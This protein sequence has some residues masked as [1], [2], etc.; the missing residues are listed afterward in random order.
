MR[1]LVTGAAGYIGST[2]VP[3]LLKEGH[4]IVALD[5]L[6]WGR[7]GLIQNIGDPNF[8]F[9]EG[10]VRDPLLVSSL[11]EGSDV[12]VHLA[13]MVGFPLCEK[14]HQQATDINVNGTRNIYRHLKDN[15]LLVYASTG[16]VYGQVKGAGCTEDLAINPQTHYATTKAQ[17]ESVLSE[18]D[19]V[20]T[21]RFATAFGFSPRMRL[22]LLVNQFVYEA[23]KHKALVVFEK[24]FVRPVIHVRDIANSISFAIKNRER[25]QSQTFNVGSLD[26]MPT[27]EQIALEIKRHIDYDLQFKDISVDRDQRNYRL[28]VDKLYSLGYRPTVSLDEGI[29]ELIPAISALHSEEHCFNR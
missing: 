19:N 7:Q 22:D 14:N 29:C 25:M 23:V 12:V 3:L 28:S 17:A 4:S 18:K 11:L 13:A 10:D 9:V 16:S 6:T 8:R 26:L 27:K 5:T 1:I 24:D 2:L 21:L 15:Q 20:I